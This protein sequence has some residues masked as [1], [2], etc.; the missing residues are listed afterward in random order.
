M[1]EKFIHKFLKVPYRLSVHNFNS[2]KHPAATIILIHGIGTSWKTWQDVAKKIPSNIRVIAVDL[3]GFGNSPKPSWQTYNAKIQADCIATTLLSKGLAGPVYIY[4]HSLGSL[5]AVEL[6]KRYPIMVKALV[7][8]SPPFYK[9]PK[10]SGM[11]NQERRLRRYFKMATN[12]PNISSKLLRIASDLKLWPDA[13]YIIKDNISAK[14]FL[15]TLDAAIINQTS[16]KDVTLLKQ[17]IYILCGSLDPF[18]V[19][20][21]LQYISD[22]CDNVT[23]IKIPK[24]RHEINK[25]YV[26]EIIKI[27]NK[28]FD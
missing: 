9:L 12:N 23:Y 17:P 21:N 11:F 22:N 3:L 20:S 13:G 2:P 25:R 1:W 4:G 6:A 24:I 15:K 19:K 18:V 26:D 5:V 16:L 27:T 7:L 28:L 10:D 14:A 8:C